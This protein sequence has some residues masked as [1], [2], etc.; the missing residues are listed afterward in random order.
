MGRRGSNHKIL[1]RHS[2]SLGN[3]ILILDGR[4]EAYG[5]EPITAREFSVSFKLLSRNCYISVV[6]GSGYQYEHRF[7]LENRQQ[8]AFD[9]M[10]QSP[11]HE[12]IPTSI[13]IQKFH[14]QEISGKR[15][16]F[17][18]LLTKT[19]AGDTVTTQ[20]RYSEFDILDKALRSQMSGHLHSTL[21]SLPQKVYNPFIDQFSLSFLE[22]RL[23]A[24]QQYLTTLLGN[25]KV[26]TRISA[27]ILFLIFF[28]SFFHHQA[29]YY[30]DFLCF[31][32]LDPV[33]GNVC[34]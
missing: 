26:D 8:P 27:L 25:S 5:Y 28:P 29:V 15:I 24:L 21:P 33:T 14:I 7:F 2:V 6:V 19:T 18:E 17:F 10:A 30:T 23:E 32:G 20:R 1:F 16:A 9:E 34:S 31:V 13:S 12:F 3:W 22:T 4:A 11:F